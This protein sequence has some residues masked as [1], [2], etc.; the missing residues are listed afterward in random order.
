MKAPR[1]ASPRATLR[2]VLISIWKEKVGCRKRTTR[3]H[4]ADGRHV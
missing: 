4:A 3:V 2:S 1:R